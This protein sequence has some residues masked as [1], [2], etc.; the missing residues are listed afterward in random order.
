LAHRLM[1]RPESWGGRISARGIVR[2]L[3][4]RVPAPV[5]EVS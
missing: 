3:L 2:S 1:L 4:D 5:V